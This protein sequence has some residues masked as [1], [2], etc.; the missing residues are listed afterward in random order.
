MYHTDITEPRG[1]STLFRGYK[2]ETD[3]RLARR[4]VLS[5]KQVGKMNCH[6]QPLIVTKANYHSVKV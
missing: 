1:S 2:N 3:G 5:I 6:V 4:L